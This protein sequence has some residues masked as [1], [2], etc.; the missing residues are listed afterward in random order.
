MLTELDEPFPKPETHI[1]GGYMLCTTQEPLEGSR[2]ADSIR[3]TNAVASLC[4][5]SSLLSPGSLGQS[6]AFCGFE[7]GGLHT[8]RHGT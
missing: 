5:I 3:T 8:T 1:L 2:I 4:S 7:G 6:A